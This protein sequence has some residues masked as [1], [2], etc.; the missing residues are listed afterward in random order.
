M[1]AA[2][3]VG[4]A[5]LLADNTVLDLPHYKGGDNVPRTLFWTDIG[6]FVAYF[7]LAASVPGYHLFSDIQ[8]F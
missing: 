8:V 6:L 7:L 1:L 2:V 3:L 4:L 5:A